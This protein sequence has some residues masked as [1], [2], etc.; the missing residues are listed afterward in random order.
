V[1]RGSGRVEVILARGAPLGG[2]APSIGTARAT[3]DPGDLLV[4][5]SDGLADRVGDH[6]QRFGERRLRQLLAGHAP[7]VVTGVRRLRS[8][9][10]TAMS[11]FAADVEPDDD[12]TLVVCEYRE[13]VALDDDLELSAAAPGARTHSPRAPSHPT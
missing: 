11:S 2:G 7:D 1:R 4:L 8:D 3:L 6:G 10:V 5:C 9:I 13:R 12:M